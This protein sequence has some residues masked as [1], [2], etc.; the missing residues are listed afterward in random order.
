MT[1]PIE[2]IN[3]FYSENDPAREILLLHSTQVRN[4]ALAIARKI[5]GVDLEIISAGAMLHDIGIRFCNA[6]GLGCYGEDDYLLHGILGA[7][8][9]RF[10]GFENCEIFARI[11]ERH[12][13]SGISADEIFENG[14]KLPERDYLPVTQEE[15]IICLADKFFSKSGDMQEK[16]VEKIRGELS[17][18]GGKVLDRFDALCKEFL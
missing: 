7:E 10:L 16:S 1:D 4:K 17:R 14:M 2:I 9:I 5:K 8:H 3:R 15:K 12:T 13:G 6:P 11:C 18:F